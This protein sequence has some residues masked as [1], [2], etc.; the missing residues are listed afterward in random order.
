[1]KSRIPPIYGPEPW[2]TVGA[3]TFVHWDRWFLAVLETDVGGDWDALKQLIKERCARSYGHHDDVER[4]MSHLNELRARLERQQLA[5]EDCLD[6][7]SLDR[8]VLYKARRKLFDQEAYEGRAQTEAMR[9]T[10]PRLLRA[11]ALRGHWD[12]FPVSPEPYESVFA[13][14]LE[15]RDF[16]PKGSTFGFVRRLERLLADEDRRC[17]DAASRLACYRGFL[18]ALM[19]AMDHLDDS[20]G[21]VGDLFQEHLPTYIGLPWEDT[22]ITPEAYYVDFIVFAVWDNYALTDQRLG[23]FFRSITKER[24]DLA[25]EILLTQEKQLRTLSQDF[26]SLEFYAEE[27]LDLLA[28]LY[29]AKRRYDRFVPAAA[30]MGSEKWERITTMAEL[31]LAEGRRDLAL[32][33]FA[34]ADQPGFHRDYLRQQCVKLTGQLPPERAIHSVP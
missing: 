16:Y 21:A 14:E 19:Q 4:K 6:E 9:N 27:A 26:P 22:G 20:Y 15:E 31:A 1:M 17:P 18:T 25:E 11:R 34:A 24:F 5:P 3:E 30:R 8:K 29:V 7:T 23:A 12:A 32:A 2:K 33:V 28:E 10:A 13:G